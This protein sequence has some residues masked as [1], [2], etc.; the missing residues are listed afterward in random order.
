MTLRSL[1]P[2]VEMPDPAAPRDAVV[3]GVEGSAVVTFE[4][5]TPALS[6]GGGVS[7]RAG[8]RRRVTPGVGGAVLLL[9]VS[10]HP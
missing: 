5:E 6:L 7:L 1:P 9:V 10:P 3:M 4:D 2:G 8:R